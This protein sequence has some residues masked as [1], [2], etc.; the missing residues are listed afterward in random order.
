MA[1]SQFTLTFHTYK[2]HT[3]V[4]V[5]HRVTEGYAERRVKLLSLELPEG[6]RSWE[7]M[8]QLEVLSA[9]VSALNARLQ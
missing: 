9:L 8:R 5:T 4:I 6:I 1:A 3:A 2:D 7:D